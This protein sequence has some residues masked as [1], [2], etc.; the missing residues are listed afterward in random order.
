[1][2]SIFNNKAL[3]P[4][5]KINS[6]DNTWNTK[7]RISIVLISIGVALL[8]I[9]SFLAYEELIAGVSIPQPPSLESVLYVLAV[10]TY[11]VAFIAVIAW[12]GAILVTRG[13]Q[14]L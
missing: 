9:A 4:G 7:R 10:V 5:G 1:L 6:H 13:L 11:K 8:L 12:S 2:S 3:N 14:N